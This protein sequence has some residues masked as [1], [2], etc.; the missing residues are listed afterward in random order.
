MAMAAGGLVMTLGTGRLSPLRAQVSASVDADAGV[1]REVTA[2]NLLEIRLGELAKKRTT[3]TEVTGFA[4]RMIADH[5]NMYQQWSALVGSDGKPFKPGLAQMQL[6]ELTRLEKVPT[7]EFDKEYMATMIRHHQ[8]NVQFF[9]NASNSARSNQVRQLVASG[10]PVLQ[11]HLNLAIQVGSQVGAA[12]AVATGGQQPSGNIP[13]TGWKVPGA[14]PQPAGQTP[15]ST[16]P[17]AD[18]TPTPTPP[19]ASQT[20][21]VAN[22]NAKP[23][24]KDLKKDSKFLREATQ[25]NTTE[26]RLAQLALKKATDARVRQLAKQILDDH[27]AMRNQWISMARNHGMALQPGLGSWHTER[28]QNLE[29]RLA[30]DFDKSYVTMVIQNAQDYV[31]Y[32]QKEG[33]TAHSALARDRAANDLATLQKHLSE[34]KRVAR[35]LGIDTDAVLRDRNVSSNR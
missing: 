32:F 8:D 19:V 17:V 30:S 5:T 7:T 35:Q 3:H 29:K 2:R 23:S 34:A 11:Q 16:P 10:L 13:G 25:D 22:E 4:D 21:P 27:T 20:P 33:L 28:L 6:G 24:S 14:N 31:E 12:P 9:Q 1:I 15:T 18:Q 26:I